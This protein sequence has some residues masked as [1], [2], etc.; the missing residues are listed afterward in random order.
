MR[1]I[2]KQVGLAGET[3]LETARANQVVEMVY[4]MFLSVASHRDCFTTATPD[5]VWHSVF[6][7]FQSER[8]MS[9]KVLMRTRLIYETFPGCFSKFVQY[10]DD[11]GGEYLAG[12]NLTFADLV[13]AN[14]L[15]ICEQVINPDILNEF[16]TL[17]VLKEEVLDIPEIAEYVAEMSVS[18]APG[19]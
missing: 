3:E 8:N 1:Y 15:D 10:L 16:P 6:N 17:R 2:A 7:D 14:F 12:E 5:I 9:K 18:N 19:A 4:E 11:S 13:V